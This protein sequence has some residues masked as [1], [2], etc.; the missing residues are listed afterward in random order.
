[1]ALACLG[2]VVVVLFAGLVQLD[3]TLA[4]QIQSIDVAWFEDFGRF[5]QLLG[6]W[7]VLVG[8]SGV[9]LLTGLV[10][11][12]R[13]AFVTGLDT[14]VAHGIIALLVQTLKHLIGRPRPRLSHLHMLPAGPSFES[15]WDSFPSGHSAA[16]FAIAAVI[17]AR[18]PRTG[19]IALIGAGLVAISRVIT[20][21][22]FPS[23]ILAGVLLGLTVGVVVA[24]PLAQW[25]VSIQR[26]LSRLVP[27]LV[28]VFSCIW[29]ALHES[30]EGWINVTML[31]LGATLMATG[32]L[33]GGSQGGEGKGVSTEASRLGGAG[34]VIFGLALTSGSLMV[35]S[36]VAL[37]LAGH[38]LSGETIPISMFA[39]PGTVQPWIGTLVTLAVLAG[40]VSAVQ[41]IK[42]ILPLF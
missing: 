20:G 36:L 17:A 24:N 10:L 28:V 16:A 8:V 23:D 30:P 18:C 42:G 34:L 39:V 27:Y 5:G 1:L 29:I 40:A 13:V 19:W 41:G 35:I 37:A 12:R 7:H 33:L 22:H 4:R 3:L 32:L 9:F 25:R 31:G 15:G 21:S 38:W 26:L 14:L 11:S 6:S 2:F